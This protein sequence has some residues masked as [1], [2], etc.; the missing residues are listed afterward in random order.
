MS[1]MASMRPSSIAARWAWWSRSVRSAHFVRE[2]SKGA[3]ECLVL[4]DVAG[5]HRRVTGALGR[6]LTQRE[7]RSCS[8]R[9]PRTRLCSARLGPVWSEAWQRGES[10]DSA[11]VDSGS[12]MW[13]ASPSTRPRR[14]RL[15]RG[16]RPPGTGETLRQSARYHPL[17]QAG[18]RVKSLVSRLRRRS[19]DRLGSAVW[20]PNREAIHC[21]MT[22]CWLRLRVP[23]ATTVLLG[24]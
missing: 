8:T 23:C 17:A 19:A 21:P 1:S 10:R 24:S 5:D 6:S 18:R 22:R 15:N 14:T 16:T 12:D 9:E 4:T 3:L 20:R 7:H 13:D 2:C 11:L